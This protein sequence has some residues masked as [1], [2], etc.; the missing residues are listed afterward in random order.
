MYLFVYTYAQHI[1][2]IMKIEIIKLFSVKIVEQNG[3]NFK[4]W[5]STKQQKTF[6]PI[7]V[8]FINNVSSR[9]RFLCKLSGNL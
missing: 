4:C 9:D 1:L 3:K 5:K 8:S 2:D 6:S 7:Q